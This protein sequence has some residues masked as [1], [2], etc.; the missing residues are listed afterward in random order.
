MENLQIGHLW[1]Q[2]KYYQITLS[3]EILHKNK[4]KV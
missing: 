2:N 1:N 4:E 3:I